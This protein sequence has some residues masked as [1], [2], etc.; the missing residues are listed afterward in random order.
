MLDRSEHDLERVPKV[1]AID[2]CTLVHG[3]LKHHLRLEGVDLHIA[4][5]AREGVEMAERIGPDVILL[6]IELESGN[7]STNGFEVLASIKE[8]STTSESAVIFLSASESTADRVRALDLGAVDFIKKPFDAAELCARVRSAVR[9]RRMMRM[10]AQK[11]SLDGLT[12]L[13]NRA[14]FDRRLAEEVSESRRYG[15]PLTLVLADID[16]FKRIND[17]FGHPVGDA[18]ISRFA[19]ILATGRASDIPCRYGGEEFGLILPG[20][21]AQSALEVAERIRR[22]LGEERW[23]CREALRVTASFG[24]AD[25]VSAER[26]VPDRHGSEALVAAADEALYR[27]KAA[28][29][30]RVYCLAGDTP[31][32]RIA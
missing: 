16:H 28:G 31:P 8:S 7:D 18:V 2:D 5:T 20:I 1:L 14:H 4:S 17:R 13:W 19:S 30:D 26:A 6:D 22:R 24:I 23:A 12:G 10:L 11:A 3:L 15:R 32:R 21:D 9:L 29:R 25:L 27:A